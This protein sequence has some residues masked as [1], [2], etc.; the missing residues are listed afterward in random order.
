V[1]KGSTQKTKNGINKI[2]NSGAEGGGWSP[3]S[4]TLLCLLSLWKCLSTSL[5]SHSNPTCY[6]QVEWPGRG[7]PH[8]LHAKRRN[9]WWLQTPW[10]RGSLWDCNCA[11]SWDSSCPGA[12]C[13]EADGKEHA[14]SISCNLKQNPLTKNIGL[15]SALWI[16]MQT[17]YMW[18]TKSP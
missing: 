14:N 18:S 13:G 5:N 11:K 4:E 12:E 2:S 16:Q 17:L 1:P 6:M 3:R 15:S 7:L 10:Y 9:L 8:P